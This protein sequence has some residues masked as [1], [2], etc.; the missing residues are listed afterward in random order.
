[1]ISTRTQAPPEPRRKTWKREVAVLVLALYS[2]A[3][4][5]TLY[6]LSWAPAEN[7]S[8]MVS[9][10][11]AAAPWV[12]ALVAGAFGLDGYAKQIKDQDHERQPD[13]TP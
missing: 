3:Y 5:W 10:I 11:N 1:M 7:A 12:A 4:G 8:Q 9:L 6:A 2:A 13:T